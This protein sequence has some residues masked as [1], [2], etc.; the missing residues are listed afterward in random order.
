VPTEICVRLLDI[1]V[2]H[3]PNLFDVDFTA[4]MEIS[5]NKISDGSQTPH[6]FLGNVWGELV[7]LLEA[8]GKSDSK[9]THHSI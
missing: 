2:R 6:V 5:L 1:L 4:R 8:V 7:I 3:F 9:T